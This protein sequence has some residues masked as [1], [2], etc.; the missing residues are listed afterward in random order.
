M[1][2]HC[3]YIVSYFSTWVLQNFSKTVQATITKFSGPVARLPA[4]NVLQHWGDLTPG[5]WGEKWEN[6]ST[7]NIS[8]MS[9]KGTPKIFSHTGAEGTHMHAY[10]EGGG[11]ERVALAIF[12]KIW[13]QFRR[14][15]RGNV[16]RKH[17]WK[18]QY[19]F[20]ASLGETEKYF[21]YGG[22]FFD[23]FTK[24]GT[25]GP[26]TKNFFLTFFEQSLEGR[27]QKTVGERS[28]FYTA[29][30]RRTIS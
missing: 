30:Y 24:G 9:G 15:K 19:S 21:A 18:F 1:D 3:G 13:P 23:I 11:L 22:L 12:W 10:L 5:F 20:C 14:P 28:K 7:P 25:A 4:K 8:P 26:Q 6:F 27:W 17:Y 2:L 29:P 16:V